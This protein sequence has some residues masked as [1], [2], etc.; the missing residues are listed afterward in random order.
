M[1][2]K[3]GAVNAKKPRENSGFLQKRCVFQHSWKRRDRDSNPG[4][5]WGYSG[6]QDRFGFDATT[7]P[8][9]SCGHKLM[10][11]CRLWCRHVESWE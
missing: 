2:P 8:D 11:G 4:Y 5:P 1:Q 6:F 10:L 3:A 7:N 9:E